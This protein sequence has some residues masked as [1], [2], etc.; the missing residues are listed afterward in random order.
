MFQSRQP[1][2]GQLHSLIG[3]VLGQ[4]DGPFIQAGLTA[5]QQMV[6]GVAPQ[7]ADTR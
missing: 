2:N 1:S 6:D 3:V 5:A 7:L 4:R